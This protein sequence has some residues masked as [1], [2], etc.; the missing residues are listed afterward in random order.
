[1]GE[2]SPFRHAHSWAC[3]S[4]SELECRTVPDASPG[5]NETRPMCSR[6]ASPGVED[7]RVPQRIRVARDPEQVRT[8]LFTVRNT[9][10]GYISGQ[11]DQGSRCADRKRRNGLRLEPSAVMCPLQFMEG[12]QGNRLS[13]MSTPCQ[14]DQAVLRQALSRVDHPDVKVSIA[15]QT[16]RVSRARV[17]LMVRSAKYE[18]SGTVNRVRWIREAAP[19]A[20]WRRCYRTSEAPT[21][22]P[23]IESLR[24]L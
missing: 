15:G 14:Q 20:P 8:P 23:S 10:A 22:Q 19:A 4:R 3:A 11:V 24:R 17:L 9:G 1:M 6:E 21:L 5:S 16:I 18:W 13:P 12:Q 2:S 7:G